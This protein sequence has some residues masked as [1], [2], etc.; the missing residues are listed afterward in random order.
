[1]EMRVGEPDYSIYGIPLAKF[2]MVSINFDYYKLWLDKNIFNITTGALESGIESIAGALQMGAGAFSGD[3]GG[4]TSGGVRSL[5][6]YGY[7]YNLMKEMYNKRKIPPV[8]ISQSTNA[9]IYAS[10]R[11]NSLGFKFYQFCV[12]KEYA[13]I[14]DDFF[15]K[16]G[17][18][19]MK[20]KIPNI[21]GR[22]NWNYV[23]TV[24]ACVDSET[25]PEKY[26]NEFK[27]ML[28]R[29]I[30]FWHNPLYFMDYSQNN[31]IV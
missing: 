4:I 7:G 17:Y 3:V 13:I 27:Q 8:T 15:S 6:I 14:I 24:E 11:I 5:G 9:E 26:I 18:K 31:N 20:N 23:K 29:G 28:N 25:V 1:M 12:K 22:S 10:G 30:T 19:T 2:P 16:F 21:T